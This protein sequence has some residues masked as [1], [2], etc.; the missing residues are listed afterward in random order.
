MNL[1]ERIILGKIHGDFWTTL[2][3]E[4]VSPVQAD[5]TT[6]RGFKLYTYCLVCSNMLAAINVLDGM[7]M[8][9][10]FTPEFIESEKS[11]S[12]YNIDRAI[13]SK[14]HTP[15]WAVWCLTGDTVSLGIKIGHEINQFEQTQLDFIKRNHASNKE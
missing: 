1:E 4:V 6:S 12:V 13:N 11:K 10:L 7:R 15:T 5:D 14:V 9:G 2:E 3:E 8:R